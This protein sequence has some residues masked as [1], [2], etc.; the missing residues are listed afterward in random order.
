MVKEGDLHRL[1]KNAEDAEAQELHRVFAE[2]GP[3]N[4]EPQTSPSACVFCWHREAGLRSS[5]SLLSVFA[6]ESM[7]WPLH[8]NPRAPVDL[9]SFGDRNELL[10]R[11]GKGTT[12]P[13]DRRN[14]ICIPAIDAT[15]SA[16]PHV[17]ARHRHP[18]PSASQTRQVTSSPRMHWSK[19]SNLPCADRCRKTE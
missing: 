1:A 8:L 15:L 12:L 17:L 10:G 9:R 3:M 4:P 19:P 18:S 11:G 16:Y 6:L 5:P 2:D 14:L 13:R 7:A